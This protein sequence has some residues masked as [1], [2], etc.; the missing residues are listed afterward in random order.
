VILLLL[1]ATVVVEG[2]VVKIVVDLLVD[3]E[4]EEMGEDRWGTDAVGLKE[5]G[6]GVES[7]TIAG[8]DEYLWPLLCGDD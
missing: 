2:V 4:E 5:N 6:S 7:E 8:T 1:Y 3:D